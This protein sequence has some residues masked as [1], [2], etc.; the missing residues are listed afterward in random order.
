M[1]L[2]TDGWGG[3]AI[4]IRPCWSESEPGF[5]WMKRLTG[6][7]VRRKVV[8]GSLTSFLSYRFIPIDYFGDKR[9]AR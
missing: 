9:L 4:M 3:G 6:K 1:R 2:E 8:F 7:T 5:G